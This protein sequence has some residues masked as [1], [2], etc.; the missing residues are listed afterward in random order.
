MGEQLL[1]LIITHFVSDW[2]FQ[3]A[4]WAV[5]K[6]SNAKH[7]FFHSLQYTALFIPVL[8]LLNI[9]LLW[10]IWIFLTHF[11]IDDY[12]IVNWWNVHIKKEKNKLPWLNM[13]EDQ[14]LHILILV[15]LILKVPFNI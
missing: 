14:I 3:P 9:S 6:S 10:I 15:P 12:K 13:V 8:Y 4:K 5:S 2:F 7:R 11:F 1:F